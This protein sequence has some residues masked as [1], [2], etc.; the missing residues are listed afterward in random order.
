MW[1]LCFAFSDGKISPEPGMYVG[2]S[3]TA[4][5]LPKE[6]RSIQFDTWKGMTNYYIYRI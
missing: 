4:V 1:S 2:E 3:A 5:K 6:L